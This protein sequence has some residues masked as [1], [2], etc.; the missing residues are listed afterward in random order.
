MV[1]REEIIEEL[2]KVNDPE[3]MINIIDLGLVYR[4]DVKK[5]AIEVDFTL[6]YPGCPA[7]EIIQK[8]IIDTLRQSTGI[9]NIQADVVWVPPWQ[10]DLMSEDARI[11]LG[12]PI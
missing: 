10:P 6:T 3:L 11:T 4:V 8:E 1:S 12:Y 9:A 7:G 2:K 5:D